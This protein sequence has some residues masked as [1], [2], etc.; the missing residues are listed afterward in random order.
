[1]SDGLQSTAFCKLDICAAGKGYFFELLSNIYSRA[2]STGAPISAPP[3]HI[4]FP[5][6]SNCQKHC[7][8]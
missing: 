6:R 2:P 3:M 7:G 1:M 5:M 4:R 8:S